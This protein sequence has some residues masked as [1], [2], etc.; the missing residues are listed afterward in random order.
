ME[1]NR[2]AVA[3]MTL[4]RNLNILGRHQNCDVQEHSKSYVDVWEEDTSETS[5][6][7]AEANNWN[8]IIIKII[9][10]T[11]WER[12]RLKTYGDFWNNKCN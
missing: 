11:K 9:G 3:W 8:R 2:V 10:D 5:K 6:Q 4:H 12:I 7:K 1:T